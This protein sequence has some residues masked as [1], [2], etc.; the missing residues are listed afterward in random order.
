[1]RMEVLPF[2]AV[3][4]LAGGRSLRP[5]KEGGGMRERS[6]GPGDRA[7]LVERPTLP[8]PSSPVL[9]PQAE[10]ETRIAV[11][12]CFGCPPA[13]GRKVPARASAS[14]GRRERSPRAGS[15]SAVGENAPPSQLQRWVSHLALGDC[16]GDLAMFRVVADGFSPG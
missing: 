15:A 7:P 9:P 13:C 1:M 5:T 3:L 2:L 12:A 8:A 4:P 16:C 14:G 10:G 11:G 6:L